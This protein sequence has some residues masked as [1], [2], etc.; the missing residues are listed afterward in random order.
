M[1]TVQHHFTVDVEE[2][3]HPSALEPF[4]ARAS[5]SSLPRRS[6]AVIERLLGV[7]DEHAARATFFTLG[8]LA[9]REPAMV[10]AIADAGH[11]IGSHSWDH[12]RV[13]TQ[14]V[15][16]FRESLRR[17]KSVLE[18][19][20]GVRVRGFRAPS[21]SI[22]P[23]VEWALDALL[24]EGYE[25][26]SSLF[27]VRQHPTYG[28]PGTPADPYRIRRGERSIVEIPPSTLRALGTN[29]PASGG[30]YLRFFPLGLIRGAF[31]QAERRGCSATFYIHPW[32]LDEHVP[33]VPMSWIA[34]TRT[35]S[36]LG[37]TWSRVRALLEEFRFDRIDASLA[38]V[39][40]AGV[41]LA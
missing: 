35:F 4:V 37:D 15:A 10:R 22:V 40:A 12:A 30:A 17:S 24:D 18:D 39:P 23:G 1:S 26:D 5:W 9:E 8:W 32:E 28:Y 31:H 36:S 6:P 11:E 19:V 2:Y 14:T 41:T 3:F 34:R 25:Y 13:T 21:F 33:D 29:V 7:L 27:P 16:E 20:A 38:S